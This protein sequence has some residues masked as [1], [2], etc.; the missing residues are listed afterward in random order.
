[1]MSMR[2]MVTL[3]DSGIAASPAERRIL[4]DDLADSVNILPERL[5]VHGVVAR[6]FLVTLLEV[7]LTRVVNPWCRRAGLHNLRLAKT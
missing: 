2:C 3:V 5:M 1:M 7:G 4:I 6:P